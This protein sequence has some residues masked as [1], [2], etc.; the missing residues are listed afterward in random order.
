MTRKTK[1]STR[2][3]IIYIVFTLSLQNIKYDITMIL[4][5]NNMHYKGDII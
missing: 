4:L 3:Y 1:K 5:Y 2:K